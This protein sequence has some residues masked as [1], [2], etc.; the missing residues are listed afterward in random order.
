MTKGMAR[1]E[2]KARG[3]CSGAEWCV[4]VFSRRRLLSPA[5]TQ[6]HRQDLFQAECC[7]MK[8]SHDHG[9]KRRAGFVEDAIRNAL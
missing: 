1:H 2:S 9:D 6:A 7:A 3:D 5:L 4:V 8:L